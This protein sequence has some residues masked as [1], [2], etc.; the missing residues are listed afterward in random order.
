MKLSNMVDSLVSLS[1]PPL[2]SNFDTSTSIAFKE[3]TSILVITNAH[4]VVPFVGV[5]KHAMNWDHV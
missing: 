5:G 4:K 1:I 2:T 3:S